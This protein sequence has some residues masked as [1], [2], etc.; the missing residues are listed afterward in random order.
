MFAQ[1]WSFKNFFL[2]AIGS[3]LHITNYKNKSEG[4]NIILFF[5]SIYLIISLP[6]CSRLKKAF[7]DLETVLSTEKDLNEHEA[8]IAAQAVLKEAGAQLPE[9]GDI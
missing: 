6:F 1:S 4:C 8:Y 7:A 2:L 5:F 3:C 9:S